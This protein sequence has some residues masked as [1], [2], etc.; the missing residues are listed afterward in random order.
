MGRPRKDWVPSGEQ[1]S[2]K[3]LMEAG[4]KPPITNGF[5]TTITRNPVNQDKK[6]PPMSKAELIRQGYVTR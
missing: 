4:K 6:I 1:A 5:A 3:T 2:P